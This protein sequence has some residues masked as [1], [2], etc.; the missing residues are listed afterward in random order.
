MQNYLNLLKT[1]GSPLYVYHEPVLRDRCSQIRSFQDDIQRR[2]SK[3]VTLH[4]SPKANSNSTILEIIK[5]FG[6][7]VDAMSPGELHIDEICGFNSKQIL[8]VCNNISAEEMKAVHKKGILVCLDSVSQVNTWGKNLPNTDIMV[9]I[10]PEVAGVGYCDEVDTAS[11]TTKFGIKEQFL[12]DLF[13]TAAKY[14]LHIVGTH[15]HLGSLFLNDKISLYIAGV[16][17]GL[18]I[19]KEHFKDV[20]IVDL[21]GGFGVPYRPDEQPL[22][23][24]KLADELVPVL[25]DF[26]KEYPSVQEFKF[27]PGRFIPCESGHLLGT[28]T[29]TKQIDSDT[30]WIGT[31]VGM[32]TLVRPS[33]YKAYHEISVISTNTKTVTANFCGNV[34][35]S[36][37]I[38]GR[39][40]NVALP[41]VDDVVLIHNAGAYG[42]SMASNYT[43]RYRPAEVLLTSDGG[44]KQIR[45]RETYLDL[46]ATLI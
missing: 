3:T 40:R 33:I 21:G 13:E 6:I 18:Q 45:R 35:E 25:S 42:Y 2:I 43:G 38:L 9:R 19:V 37:D 23:L 15:Q 44:E 12:P 41:D 27:E 34:C 11:K 5:S 46:M 28:V 20:K 8:Y 14:N 36:G 30:W 29:A 16:K 32:G 31:D 22:D 7:Y 4:Y 10:N 26:I 1:Y 17:A 24:K 39:D